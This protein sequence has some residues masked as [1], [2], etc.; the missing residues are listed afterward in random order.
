MSDIYSQLKVLHHPDRLDDLAEG[1]RPKPI[2]VQLI[3]SDLCNQDCSFCAYR[4][5][6]GLSSELFAEGKLAKTGHNNPVRQIPTAKAREIIEDCAELGVKAIQFTGGGE[7][8]VHPAHLELFGLAQSLDIETSLVTNGVRLSPESEAI[9]GMSW[10]R[11]S[12]D[13]GSA[14]DY[15]A[16]RRVP[17]QHWDKVWSNLSTLAPVYDG[18]LGVGFV[19]T[20]ENYRGIASAAKLAKEAGASNMRVGAVFSTEGTSFYGDLIP[21]IMD[22]IAGAKASVDSGGFE[23]IDLFGRRLGDLE[24]GRPTDPV[25]SYQYLTVYI[26]GDLNVYRC[27]NTAY[28]RAGDVGS[29]KGRRLVDAWPELGYEPFDARSCQHCQFLGQNRAIR[30]LV[31]RPAHVNF[32]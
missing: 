31:D 1:R 28:T 27:C 15:Q 6:A 29:L 16:V 10:I 23:I 26:G 30:S 24:E 8:T 3:L 5:S 2:H 19:I 14:E 7:P 4:M 22:T 32:V 25:C 21:E 12:I 11:V 18:V 13:S 17:A 20:P 9:L